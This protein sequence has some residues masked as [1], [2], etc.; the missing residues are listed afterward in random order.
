MQLTGPARDRFV[1]I[2]R[3]RAHETGA[4]LIREA[5]E[6]RDVFLMLSGK[7]DVLVH[8]P[9]GRMVI[10]SRVNPGELVG[11]LA[12]IDNG[13][14]SASVV[15]CDDGRTAWVTQTQFR[16]L[17]EQPEFSNAIH[18]HFVARIRSLSER[19][20]EFGTLLVRERLGRELLRL[21][22]EAG[23]GDGPHVLNP[24][25]GHLELAARIATHREAVSR[26]MSRLAR[27]GVLKRKGR[28]LQI[29]SCAA[30]AETLDLDDDGK[31]GRITPEP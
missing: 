30:L 16:M 22:H 13:A 24:A 7:A 27:L 5:G 26:E 15:A 12:A 19:V 20:Y 4:T 28:A 21:A 31:P 9:D 6:G 23:P 29:P 10:Y 14:R 17:M 18:L 25:P 2:A 3:E 8:S 11:V 1:A